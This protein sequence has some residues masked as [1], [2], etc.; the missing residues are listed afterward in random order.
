MTTVTSFVE[1]LAKIGIKVELIG[2]Y[3]WVYLDKINNKKVT[4]KFEANHGFTVFFSPIRSDQ[5]EKITNISE[6]FK[7]IRKYL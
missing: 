6:I 4:E 3:P 5:N 2:N 7:L 1:R